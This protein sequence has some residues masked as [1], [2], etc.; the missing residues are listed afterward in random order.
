MAETKGKIPDRHQ[1]KLHTKSGNRCAIC[2]KILVNGISNDTAC[3]GENAHIY[4]E[5]AGSARY[6][7]NKPIEYVNSYENL[8]YAC[9]SCHKIIDT[10]ID[11]F[12][13]ERLLNIKKDHEEWVNAQLEEASNTYTFA[14]LEVLAKY[15]MATSET[16]SSSDFNVT[17]INDKINKN[18]LKDFKKEINIGLIQVI[19]IE[20]YL[21]RHPDI[22]FAQ[23][24][25]GF[26]S[27]KY[28]ELK[29]ICEDTNEIFIKMWDIVSGNS[30][31]FS[32]KAA[33]LGI[34]VY[35]FEKCEVFEK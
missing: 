11:N 16:S 4:G 15:L 30:K 27:D 7:K 24:L 19:T 25:N 10:E 31:E 3:V 33:G 35:F 21:S 23:R 18:S 8:I 14:E 22:K 32:Y 34:L 9:A 20:D 12:P 28:K 17:K 26:M 5:K 2:K 13:P 1:R 29:K 6:D